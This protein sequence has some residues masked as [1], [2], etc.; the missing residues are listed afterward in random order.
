MEKE[1]T[2]EEQ[3]INKLQDQGYQYLTINNLADLKINLKAQIEKLNNYTF[4]SDLDFES[5]YNWLDTGDIFERSKRI[6]D[7]KFSFNDCSN[8]EQSLKAFDPLTFLNNSFQVINQFQAVGKNSRRYDVTILVNGLPLVQIELKQRGIELS[9][10]F[11]QVRKYGENSYNN[12]FNFLQLFI[13]SSGTYTKYFATTTK[14]GHLNYN[15]AFTW[16]D[17]DNNKINELIS[18]NKDNHLSFSEA[19]LKREHLFKMLADYMVFQNRK[20]N[21]SIKVLRPYQ[22][23]A[24]EAIRN[25]LV[26]NK[27]NGYIWH[28]T[29]SGKTLTSFKAADLIN[30]KDKEIDG[31][32]FVVDRIDLNSQTNEEFS[33]FATNPNDILNIENTRDLLNQF[34]LVE[35][36]QKKLIITTIQKLTRAIEKLDKKENQQIKDKKILFIFD[37]C[38]RSQFGDQHKAICNYFINSRMIGFTG[39]PIFTENAWKAGETTAKYFDDCLHKYTI[40]E[41]IT[42]KNVLRFSIEY[43]NTWN[44]KREYQNEA[45]DSLSDGEDIEDVLKEVDAS[46]NKKEIWEHPD[47]IKQN[48]KYVFETIDNKTKNKKFNALFVCSN[49]SVLIK[50]Y[51]E[52]IKQNDDLI[53]EKQISLAAIF[54][55]TLD[56]KT[57]DQNSEGDKEEN[58][59]KIINNFYQFTKTNPL[60]SADFGEQDKRSYRERLIKN[61][62][63]D[64]PTKRVNLVLV[65]NMLTTGFDSKYLNTIYLDK[66][67]EYHNLIQTFSRTNRTMDGSKEYGNIVSFRPLKG[68]TDEAIKLF[69]SGDASAILF[70]QKPYLEYVAEFNEL[71]LAM[72]AKFGLVE[73]VL[74]LKSE[75]EKR[76]FVLEFRNL[77]PLLNLLKTFIEF[78]HDDLAINETNYKE[79]ERVYKNLYRESQDQEEKVSGL[80][81]IDFKVELLDTSIVDAEYIEKMLAKDPTAIDAKE[82]ETLSKEVIDLLEKR[83]NYPQKLITLVQEFL[84]QVLSGMETNGEILQDW[85]DHNSLVEMLNDFI[86]KTRVDELF[87]LALEYELDQGKFENVITKYEQINEFDLQDF[88]TIH[89]YYPLSKQSV[90]NRE[91]IAKIETIYQNTTL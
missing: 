17:V 37:E 3:L 24:I 81:L 56:G 76:D 10:A 12:L 73:E 82:F 42:D 57:D 60:S 88:K 70:D 48:V 14:N 21:P 6:R 19:F 84:D 79:Y 22:I 90:I 38:H 4:K 64:N 11:N 27:R 77:F 7:D 59:L 20:T 74:N 16:T 18:V 15:Q 63:G 41:A 86:D 62:K 46:L 69:S 43:L 72:Q 58:L 29:G 66:N 47:R 1:S 83:S 67:V 35:E 25:Q 91:I 33:D 50:Y 34:K 2:L 80:N 52:F 28:T 51:D 87:E 23:Y 71:I 53:K 75:E 13:I 54:S 65:V 44:L 5:F 55:S 40:K 8:K 9:E 31:V 89:K 49:I 39:T 32:I 78:D 85:K 30:S 45:K 61:M 26:T 36:G 68:K